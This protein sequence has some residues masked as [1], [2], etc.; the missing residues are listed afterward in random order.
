MNIDLKSAGWWYGAATLVTLIGGLYGIPEMV[1]G[2][3]G[4]AGVQIVHLA[5]TDGPVSFPVQVRV[6]LLLVLLAGL[7][8]ATRWIWWVPAIGLTA[9]LSIGYCMMAR[10]LSL[11]PW[12]RKQPLTA[13]LIR[14]TFLTPPTK[15]SILNSL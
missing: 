3:V 5:V 7:P 1:Y 10:I 11:F 9:R 13:E 8:E 15:G 6:A 4:L 2:A 12:N 14:K